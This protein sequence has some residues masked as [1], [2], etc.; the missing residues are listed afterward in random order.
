MEPMPRFK[1]SRASILA[2]KNE[3]E[4]RR[5][6]EEAVSGLDGEEMRSLPD[7]CQRALTEKDLHAAAVLML[8]CDLM[9][10]GEAQAGEL[11]RQLAELYASA[12]VRLSQLERPALPASD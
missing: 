8:R 6:L 7:E 1:S 3:R 9:H 2:A 11:L 10:R 4:V 5:V 12:S